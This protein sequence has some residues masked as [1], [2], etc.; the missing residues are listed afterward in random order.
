[1]K[2]VLV[3]GTWVRYTTP[4]GRCLRGQVVGPD[5]D[6]FPC[7]AEVF[8]SLPATGFTRLV[9]VTDL[10]VDLPAPASTLVTRSQRGPGSDPR[11][12]PGADG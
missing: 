11:R 1:M 7:P 5:Q 4:D 2:S 6:F 3:T 12:A 8:V 10:T 9:P